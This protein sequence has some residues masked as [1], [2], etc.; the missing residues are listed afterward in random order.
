MVEGNLLYP[1]YSPNFNL[2]LK[3]SLQ[4]IL[5]TA[6]LITQCGVVI[7]QNQ[8]EKDDISLEFGSHNNHPW[9]K[10]EQKAFISIDE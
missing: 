2:S 3:L 4:M 10:M 9:I 8:R 5:S 1:C 7:H 6:T